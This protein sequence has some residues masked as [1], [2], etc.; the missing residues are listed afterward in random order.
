MMAEKILET[1]LEIDPVLE[2][3]EPVTFI[4]VREPYDRFF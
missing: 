1:V 4:G 2:F 3:P